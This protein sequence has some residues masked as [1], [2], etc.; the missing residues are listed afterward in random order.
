MPT[1]EYKELS[2][3]ININKDAC[4]FYEAATEHAKD[5]H[6]KRTFN[7]LRSLHMHVI[8]TLQGHMRA[9]G[10]TPEIKETISGK[11]QKFWSH[12]MLSVS[13]DVDETLVH[14]LEEA[15]DRCLNSMQETLERPDISPSTQRV[16]KRE[17]SA[18]EKSH[19]YMKALKDTMDAA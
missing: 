3:L 11:A 4:T 6:F 8:E 7:D 2:M 9:N 16:L 17:Y 15:E 14:H 10:D 1:K 18:L 19:D 12:V 13:N 5:A